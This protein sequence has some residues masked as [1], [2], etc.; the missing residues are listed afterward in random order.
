ARAASSGAASVASSAEVRPVPRVVATVGRDGQVTP[1]RD[2]G[3]LEPPDA[4]AAA[5]G[6][7]GAAQR[8]ARWALR[9]EEMDA[10]EIRPT[11]RRPIGAGRM[12]LPPLPPGHRE[13]LQHV[14]LADLPTP[15]AASRPTDF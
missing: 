4:A 1:V 5:V 15:P 14:T 6:D 3:V 12:V 8:A 13:S 2:S 11:S 7:G 9:Q 10:V